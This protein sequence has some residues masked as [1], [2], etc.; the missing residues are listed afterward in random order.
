MS[1]PRTLIVIASAVFL[2]SKT[3]RGVPDVTVGQCLC[4]W[5]DVPG[6]DEQYL[7]DRVLNDLVHHTAGE[8]FN[9]YTRVMLGYANFFGHA[10]CHPALSSM[11]CVTCLEVAD[12]KML[13]CCKF[14]MGSRIK[15]TSCSLRVEPLFFIDDPFEGE[16]TP[17]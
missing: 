16:I 4:G 15:L 13:S 14:R 3:I 11:D 12:I 5:K 8:G 1:R 7:K 2:I 10:F 6:S 17:P 9:H